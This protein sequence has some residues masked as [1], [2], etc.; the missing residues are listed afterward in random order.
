M[1]AIPTV[2]KHPQAA[3]RYIVTVNEGDSQTKH[4]VRL[5]EEMH[6]QMVRNQITPEELVRASFVFLLEREAKESILDKFDL[7]VIGH[8]F[9]E[10]KRKLGDYIRTEEELEKEKEAAAAEE[11]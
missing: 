8:Y 10:Y 2:Q 4:I 1:S 9:P 5:S 3:E 11:A 7:P 6:W